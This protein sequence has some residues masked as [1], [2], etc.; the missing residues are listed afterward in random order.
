[1]VKKFAFRQERDAGGNN[2]S[3]VGGKMKQGSKGVIVFSILIIVSLIISACQTAAPGEAEVIRET[4][5]ITQVIEGTP[6]EVVIT[7]TPGEQPAQTTPV[8]QGQTIPATGMVECLPLPDVPEA[9]AFN[10]QSVARVNPQPATVSTSAEQSSAVYGKLAPVAFQQQQGEVYNVGV[11]SDVTTLNYWAGNGPDNTVWNSY[12]LPP[13]LSMFGLSEQ[14]FA[15]TPVAAAVDLPDPLVEEGGFFVTEVPMRQDITWSD[16]QPFTANDVA[17]TAN[18]V[19]EL[20]LLS[21]N[22]ASWYDSNFLDRVEAVDDYTVRY[23]FHTRPGL[24][25]FEYG[26]LTAPILAEHYWAPLVE[27]ALQPVRA[28]GDNPNDDDLLGAQQEAQ[29]ELFAHDP[30]AEPLAGSF[31][32]TRWEPGAFFDNDANEDYFLTGEVVNIY[33]G[34]G[35][36]SGDTTVGDVSGTPMT[37]VE[38]GPHVEAVVYTIYGT[39]DAAIL[40]LRN[41]EVDFVLNSLGLQRGLA[42]QIRNDPNLTVVENPTNGFRYLSFNNR[43]EPMNDCSFR[44]AVAVLIDKEFVTN[45]ILQGVAYPLYTFVPEGN[46]AWYTDDVPM[47]GQGLNRQQRLNL[48]IAILEQAGYSFEGGNAPTFDTTGQSVTPG[49][50]LLMPDGNPVPNL[51][52]IA[53]SAGYDPLRS[54]FA[55]WIETWLTEFGIPTNA[56]LS[57][58]NV[59]VPRI[60]TEQ[61]F[62]MYI[63]GWSLG[64]FPD[65]LYDFFAEEQAVLDGNNAGGYVNP[66]FE[67]LANNILTCTDFDECRVYSDQIQQLL[68]TEVP[69]VVLFD[70][71]IIEAYRSASID[72]PFTQQLS[73]LQYTHQGGGTMQSAVQVR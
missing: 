48:A 18:A 64:I 47:I 7:A 10:G 28:L 34:G 62:D 20:G 32:Y 57:G 50:R 55:I 54:T 29:Q 49:G 73:G 72:F 60:F 25:R 14:V 17:F 4:V 6:V 52:L 61:D 63:L 38:V 69:Y 35:Y 33:E 9:A 56:E 19:L 13:R 37:T 42:D 71:G 21:G 16:G 68:A 44:Q 66:E 53:P 23:V 67:E 22:W 41:G 39:Q 11:F 1:L 27:D 31:L 12:M 26:V 46:A 5:V 15:F 58:F 40:A 43:R 59:L 36:Q 51:T 8:P 3:L 2:E 30:Q 45:T 65:F 24:A 70:T